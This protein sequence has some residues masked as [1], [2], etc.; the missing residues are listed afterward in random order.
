M[1]EVRLERER[2]RRRDGSGRSVR[3]SGRNG[4]SE[5]VG[6]RDAR[7]RERT[8]D[9]VAGPN[10]GVS[11]SVGDM[12]EESKHSGCCR[13]RAGAERTE[14][15]PSA[16]V[17]DGDDGVAPASSLPLLTSRLSPLTG[18]ACGLHLLTTRHMDLEDS[19]C[20]DWSTDGSCLQMAV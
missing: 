20:I 3:R 18:A 12:G 7:C 8:G 11:G 19:R 6:R 9:Q 2:K 4:W 15:R 5:K 10:T 16:A 1:E 17:A 14:S 13:T